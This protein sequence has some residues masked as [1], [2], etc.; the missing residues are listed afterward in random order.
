MSMM[1]GFDESFVQRAEGFD[2]R[3]RDELLQAAARHLGAAQLQ[4]VIDPLPARWI[5]L[6]GARQEYQEA[7]G[8]AL[9]SLAQ[10]ED[11]TTQMLLEKRDEQARVR[12]EHLMTAIRSRTLK[13][14]VVLG[15]RTR[16]QAARSL[17]AST[18]PIV[19]A[20]RD[21]CTE[22]V[23]A[24][25]DWGERLR[26]YQI[27]HG[28]GIVRAAIHEELAVEEAL[29]TGYGLSRRNYRQLADLGVPLAPRLK[30]SQSLA[31]S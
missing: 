17:I 3:V 14:G 11:G 24:E 30:G 8:S 1:D 18:A 26:G 13:G 2:F 19:D 5:E 23:I 27:E 12:G 15:M 25:R 21:R 4:L 31:A 7:C 9:L 28:A 20:L 29:L 22:E 16:V 10:S 6:C